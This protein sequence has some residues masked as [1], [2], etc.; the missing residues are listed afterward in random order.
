MFELRLAGIFQSSICLDLS[1]ITSSL[2]SSLFFF[3]S[4]AFYVSCVSAAVVYTVTAQPINTVASE[5]PFVVSVSTCKSMCA[6]LQPYLHPLWVQ[7]HFRP[8][9][10][11]IAR[12]PPPPI[13]SVHPANTFTHLLLPLNTCQN[14]TWNLCL[15]FSCTSS[16]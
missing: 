9:S 5:I 13:Y 14:W 3:I 6:S 2:A 10:S 1:I 11:K 4:S 7:S 15:I 12:P 8:N 16:C